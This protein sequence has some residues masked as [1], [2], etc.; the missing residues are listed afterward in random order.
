VK[1]PVLPLAMSSVPHSETLA[2]PNPP[3]NM[4]FCD[5][6]HRQKEGDNIYCDL[7]IVASGSASKPHLLTQVDLKDLVRDLNFSKTQAELLGSRLN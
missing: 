1:Y 4:T 2:V 6:V 7:T 5:E 3:E